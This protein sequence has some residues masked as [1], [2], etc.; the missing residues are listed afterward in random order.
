MKLAKQQ[1]IGLTL[2]FAEANIE[3]NNTVRLFRDYADRRFL[4]GYCKK[5]NQKW[6]I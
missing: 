2:N 1:E 5:E 3:E 4:I 6:I